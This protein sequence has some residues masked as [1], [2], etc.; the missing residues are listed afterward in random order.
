M[1]ENKNQHKPMKS[2]HINIHV[3]WNEVVVLV[4]KHVLMIL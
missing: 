2:E 1:Y 3:D 4:I